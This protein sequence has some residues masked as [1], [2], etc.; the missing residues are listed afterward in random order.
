MSQSAQTLVGRI[1]RYTPVAL[2]HMASP[3]RAAKVRGL[4]TK[5]EDTVAWVVWDSTYAPVWEM[6]SEIEPE[7]K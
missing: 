6:A 5:S 2:A 4:C 3:E 1:V 7:D